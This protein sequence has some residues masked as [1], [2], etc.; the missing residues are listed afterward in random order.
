MS[1]VNSEEK[2][3][4]AV[5]PDVRDPW[6]SYLDIL[7]PTRP[8]LYKFCLKLT[9]NIWDA[10]DLVQDALLRVFSLL[11]KTD[12][13]LR[14]PKAY[15]VQTAT[16]MWIDKI[17]RSASEK[18]ILELINIEDSSQQ[19]ASADAVDARNAAGQLMQRLHPQERAAIVLKDVLDLSLQ[20]TA[21]ILSTTVGAVKSALNRGRS[22]LDQRLEPAGL[23]CPSRDLVEAFMQALKNTDLETLKAICVDELAVE[24]V[25]GAESRSFDDSQT[26]FAHAHFVLPELGFGANPRWEVTLYQGEPVVLGYRTLNEVEGIN[27]VHRIETLDGK[28]T[29]IRCYCFCPNTLAAIGEDLNLVALSRPYRSPSPADYQL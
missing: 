13:D 16:H 14:N 1:D 2:S 27:E 29:R 7:A 22:R 18:A 5:Q 17:R 25:G 6:R 4:F 21:E 15:L 24:M 8:E 28:I 3:A 10:E 9:G 19:D 12:A 11:G 20:N 26:F 23:N